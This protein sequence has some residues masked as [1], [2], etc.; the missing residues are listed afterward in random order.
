M[1]GRQRQVR[2]DAGQMRYT[3]RD[4]W[5]LTW[6]GD[7]YGIRF[8]QLQ[9]LLGQRA[10][11]AMQSSTE[12]GQATVRDMV[13]R[14]QRAGLVEHRKFLVGQPGWVWLT[15]SGLEHMDLPYRVW[16]PQVSGLSHV[17]WCNQV[18]LLVEPRQVGRG[19]RAVWQSERRLRYEEEQ[20]RREARAGGTTY[21]TSHLPDAVVE[22][23]GKT[24]A[25]EVELTA[26]TGARVRDIMRRVV[27]RYGRAWYF[28]APAAATVVQRA[29]IQLEPS[30]Q[31]EVG[32]YTLSVTPLGKIHAGVHPAK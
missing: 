25:V 10:G 15:R 23:D 16:E 7:Q 21:T 17:Y 8:D 5:A 13:E 11:A 27:W 26:K 2:R 3:E 6:I 22:V 29:W 18:R 20:Q 30:V 32:F 12:L 31:R 28:V 24:I 9:R 4:M 14:W 1:N 19:H